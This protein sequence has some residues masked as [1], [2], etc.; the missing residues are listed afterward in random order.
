MFLHPVTL[1]LML[2]PAVTSGQQAVPPPPRPAEPP[3]AAAGPSLEVTLQY[4]KTKI[5]GIGQLHY[6]AAFYTSAATGGIVCAD[7]TQSSFQAAG[8]SASCV[9]RL[10][11]K[12]D[13]DSHS[14]KLPLGDISRIDMTSVNA[15]NRE[16]LQGRQ[17]DP[18]LPAL[19]I[20]FSKPS[21][22][23][24]TASVV[25]V[26]DTSQK[27]DK[28]HPQQMIQRVEEK[29]FLLKDY[30]IVFDDADAADRVAKALT[31]ASELCGAGSKELF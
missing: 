24:H 27:V 3:P 14:F 20:H 7:Y 2:V 23:V 13:Q 1:A 11:F 21:V 22:Q 30:S 19:N 18:D 8:D 26:P 12:Q 31:H 9:L 17:N 29:D 16:S 5:E 6:C 25:T 10:D 4:L 15:L 28:T